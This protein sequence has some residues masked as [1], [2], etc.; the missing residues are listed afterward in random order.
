[1]FI[2]TFSKLIPLEYSE[3]PRIHSSNCL[4]SCT[5]SFIRLFSGMRAPLLVH[6]MSAKMW[7]SILGG[8]ND[9]SSPCSNECFHCSCLSLGSDCGSDRHEKADEKGSAWL[10]RDNTE[11][12]HPKVAADPIIY[13]PSVRIMPL[14][15]GPKRIMLVAPVM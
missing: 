12:T 3:S 11:R 10:L 2:C 4:C 9:R 13:C 7:I 1:L 5:K 6:S 15:P 14:G 8:K